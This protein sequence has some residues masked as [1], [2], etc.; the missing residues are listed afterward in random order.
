M[1]AYV[2]TTGT[3]SNPLSIAPVTYQIH[4]ARV[5]V[6][7]TSSTVTGSG[8]FFV[9]SPS[10]LSGGSVVT[11]VPVRDGALPATASVKE[12]ATPS[13]T[14]ARVGRISVTPSNTAVYAFEYP[15]I[16]NL[17]SVFHA[18]C[19]TATLAFVYE[20]LHLARSL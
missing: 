6:Y 17:G 15:L 20:E 16:V 1:S 12:G 8:V 9:C 19:A 3:A 2:A 13:G 7:S 18:T 4:I 5:E 11:S 14:L 10:T